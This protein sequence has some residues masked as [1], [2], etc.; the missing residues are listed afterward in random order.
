MRQKSATMVAP[1]PSTTVVA[2]GPII[3]NVAKVTKVQHI[4]KTHKKPNG[5][6]SESAP[7]FNKQPRPRL[8]ADYFL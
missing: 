1:G 7:I 5:P 6:T 3:I 4:T 2:P 8:N